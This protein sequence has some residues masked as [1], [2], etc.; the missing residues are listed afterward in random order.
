MVPGRQGFG[1]SEALNRFLELK[2]AG[3]PEDALAALLRDCLRQGEG[4]CEKVG[5]R[6]TLAA[7]LP[8]SV[9]TEID[10]VLYGQRNR[11]AQTD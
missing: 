10:R 8:L 4:F 6:F 5:L 9:I 7:D 11:A 1:V 3:F 2:E